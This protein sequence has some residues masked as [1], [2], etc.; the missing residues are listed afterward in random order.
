[1]KKKVP[2]NLKSVLFYH[3]VDRLPPSASQPVAKDRALAELVGADV[4]LTAPLSAERSVV[5][6]SLTAAVRDAL[7]GARV[8]KL[9]FA[10]GTELECAVELNEKGDASFTLPEGIFRYVSADLHSSDAR[11]RRRRLETMFAETPLA[12]GEELA[13]LA[14]SDSRTLEDREISAIFGDVG[15]TP[16][17]LADAI[18]TSRKL[19]VDNLMPDGRLYYDRLVAPFQLDASFRDYVAGA[20]AD[21]RNSQLSR[22]PEKALRR[23]AFSG[24]TRS[25]TPFELLEHIKDASI[26]G[27]LKAE[28]PYSLLFGFNLVSV[29]ADRSGMVALGEAF[30]EKLFLDPVQSLGRR[31]LFTG[32]AAISLAWARRK[33]RAG[34][35]PAYWV[36]LAA[37][38][39]AGVLTDAR[40]EAKDPEAFAQW[41]IE[42][43]G[44]E[45]FWAT[46]MERQ[47]APRWSPE[48]LSEDHLRAD[49][50]AQAML[51]IQNMPSGGR[52]GSWAKIVEG[53]AVSDLASRPLGLLI[54][55]G[56]FD[57]F[58]PPP[59]DVE[60]AEWE[61]PPGGSTTLL[62]LLDALPFC[63]KIGQPSAAT[64]DRLI[65]ILIA[66]RD[67]VPDDMDRY[68]TALNAVADMSAAG[69]SVR[70]SDAVLDRC[71][72]LLR[73]QDA[74]ERISYLLSIAVTACSAC[75]DRKAY[76]ER[77]SAFFAGTAFRLDDRTALSALLQ[78]VDHMLVA[79]RRMAPELG[80]ARL[81]AA[82]KLRRAT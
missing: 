60:L 26:E 64:T 18:T 53:E 70:L 76:R 1:M 38:A 66:E 34:E 3:V 79:E 6:S 71:T 55:P 36:R 77:V 21:F 62:G 69:R 28:D 31:Q 43:F 41:A 47:E 82:Y 67:F 33:A 61:T 51:A 25:L 2:P 5:I 8:A 30:L 32:C 12:A 81:I 7:A 57:D 49:V 58:G 23:I 44:V 54:Y 20:L 9:A 16:E 14:L 40:I 59:N 37:L 35:A 42:N 52:V 39:H 63:A 27:L 17:A 65:G 56:P 74:Q 29:R 10:D 15:D 22:H 68:L 24:L 45:Q 73:Q 48:L 19:D 75:E 4:A 50:N 13:W 11:V 80:R 46:S 72:T 78:I